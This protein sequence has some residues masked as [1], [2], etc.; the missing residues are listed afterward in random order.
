[1]VVVFLVELQNPQDSMGDFLVQ[2]VLHLLQI[3]QEILL[4]Y[5]YYRQ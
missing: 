1:M 2:G 5:Y 4:N 3:L